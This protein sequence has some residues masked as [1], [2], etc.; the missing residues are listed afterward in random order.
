M[1]IR[2]YHCPFCLYWVYS[3]AQHDYRNCACGRIAVDGGF[4][5][6]KISFDPKMGKAPRSKYIHLKVSKDT[7]YADWN[8]N[9]DK[10]GLINEDR[11]R[12]HA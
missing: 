5:Y 6:T 1:R 2:V 8:T 11:F 4:T 7:L 12:R 3:R 10:Y 9:T